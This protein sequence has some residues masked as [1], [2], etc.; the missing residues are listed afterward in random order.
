VG[1]TRS[2]PELGAELGLGQHRQERME[3]W[4]EA[5]TGVTH[6]DAF[7]VAVL[8]EQRGGVQVEGVTLAAQRQAL[9]RPAPQRHKA[10]ETLAQAAK[11]GKE[12]RQGRLARHAPQLQH[13]GQDRVAPQP[14][15]AREPIGPRHDPRHEP[16]GDFH[17]SQRIRARWSL[18]QGSCQELAYPMILH[19]SGHKR[20]PGMGADF[21]IGG[22]DCDGLTAYF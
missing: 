22:P 6:F 19:E 17:R 4:L 12:A 10:G 9:H 15:H 8:V 13:L 21:L 11:T 20:L 2:Q 3:A 14:R 1:V 18:R 16:Q 5:Q 7:L